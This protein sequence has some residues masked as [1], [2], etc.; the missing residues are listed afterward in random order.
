[1]R[2]S[3]YRSACTSAVALTLIAAPCLAQSAAD[4]FTLAVPAQ[5]LSVTCK[6][7]QHMKACMDAQSQLNA[8]EKAKLTAMLPSM[9]QELADSLAKAEASAHP[10]FKLK[11]YQYS[12]G[13]PEK[14]ESAKPK[15]SACTPGAL[16]EQKNP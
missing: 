5:H 12:K 11:V 6:D 4:S 15:I 9:Q 14:D 1:M 2:F 10:C 16:I 7:P 13:Y 8:K 3:L